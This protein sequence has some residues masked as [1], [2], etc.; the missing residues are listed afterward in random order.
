MPPIGEWCRIFNHSSLLIQ[1]PVPL[2]PLQGPKRLKKTRIFQ[3][4]ET[5]TR[6]FFCLGST[7]AT[8]VPSRAQ[9]NCVAECSGL[10]RRK[11]IF[12]CLRELHLMYCQPYNSYNVS[13]DNLVLDQLIIPK[14]IFF[15]VLITSLV[16]IVEILWG[17]FCLDHSWG[18]KD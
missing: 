16:D 5:W 9:K 7:Q 3:V 11:V 6:N 2:L 4:K 12:F 17:E 15:F 10:G 18:L 14:L 8:S 13:S 1:P